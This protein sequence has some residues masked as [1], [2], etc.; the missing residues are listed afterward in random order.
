MN[1]ISDSNHLA[2]TGPAGGPAVNKRWRPLRTSV[3]FVTEALAA[4]TR[5]PV[6]IRV[7]MQGGDGG[8]VG[9]AKRLCERLVKQTD[10]PLVLP[11]GL[12]AC[13][14][15]VARGVVGELGAQGMGPM[16]P[17]W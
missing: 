8:A 12:G 9:A 15:R 13:V 1:W 3:D 14:S 5:H 7:R 6:E 17:W 10:P 2:V 11:G 16:G 4:T